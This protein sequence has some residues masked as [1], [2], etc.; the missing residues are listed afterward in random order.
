MM[1]ATSAESLRRMPALLLL[2]MTILQL[3]A[4]MSGPAAVS[5]PGKTWLGLAEMALML[6]LAWNGW[7][8]RDHLQISP[9]L[10][11]IASLTLASL[12]VC[13][14][15][16]LVNRNFG[17]AR[18]S[19][20]NVIEH[21]YLV[22]SIVFFFPGYLLFIVAAWLATRDRVSLTL[23]TGSLVIAA[24]AGALSF[25]GLVLPGA[26]PYVVAMTASYTLL[27]SMVS[28][29]A[30]WLLRGFGVA[31]WPVALGALLATVA[32]AIIG[33]FWLFG[34]G[35]YPAAAYINMIV[36]FLSQALL[37]Q[38]PLQL[39]TVAVTPDGYGKA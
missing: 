30:L 32:D 37:Q 19:H 1:S 29:T 14:L 21:S 18:F 23:R 28:A 27:I 5:G 35:F 36:Y 39:S 16:D 10:R 6:A 11:R 15:G 26:S 31:L 7:R 4:W 38:L 24:T 33:H 17:G 34:K 22:D 25:A 3:A 12:A 2:L 13:L 9:P 8:I 20:D